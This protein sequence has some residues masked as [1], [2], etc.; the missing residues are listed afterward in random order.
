M[1]LVMFAFALQARNDPKSENANYVKSGDKIYFCQKVKAGVFCANI[2]LEDGITMKIPFRKVDAYSCNGRL[3][4]RLPVVCEGA[5][6][7][8]TALMEYITS[9]NGL[10]LYKYCKIVECGDLVNNTYEKPHLESV[11]FVF[12]D[13]EFYLKVDQKNAPTVLPFFGIKV[14]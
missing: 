11:F 9:R 8:C 10:R 14:L 5:P 6:A 13:G 4:E 7:N 3:F 2:V 1:L 12:Q